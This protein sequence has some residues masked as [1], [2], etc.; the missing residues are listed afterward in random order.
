MLDEKEWS[1]CICCFFHC[2]LLILLLSRLVVVPSSHECAELRESVAPNVC[3]QSNVCFSMKLHN[4]NRCVGTVRLEG[5]SHEK[6]FCPDVCCWSGQSILTA[7]HHIA[8]VISTLQTFPL[9]KPNESMN[10][11]LTFAVRVT[12]KKQ[13][14]SYA[15]TSITR[16]HPGP[17]RV[18]SSFVH[19]DLLCVLSSPEHVVRTSRYHWMFEWVLRQARDV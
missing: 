15:R 9:P 6:V 19:L 16:E 4:A 12:R 11:A 13:A 18:S 2:L 3:L 7:H 5:N 10:A 14:T 1:N 17:Q 8:A